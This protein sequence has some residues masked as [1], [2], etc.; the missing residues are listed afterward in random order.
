MPERLRRLNSAVF[1][2]K[3]PNQSSWAS[4][5]SA[6]RM[7]RGR[8]SASSMAGV[9][10]RDA[11]TM[12]TIPINARR[13]NSRMGAMGLS[14]SARKPAVVVSPVSN[15]GSPTFFTDRMVTLS[16]SASSCSVS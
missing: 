10:M 12:K 6:C 16:L 14:T 3:R 8:P 1:S 4:A 15:M 13:P 7:R 9:T 11:T 2:A 5:R